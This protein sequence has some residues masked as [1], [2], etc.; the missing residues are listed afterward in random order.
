MGQVCQKIFSNSFPFLASLFE[1]YS[2]VLFNF[3]DRTI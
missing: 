1:F 3:F 2:R